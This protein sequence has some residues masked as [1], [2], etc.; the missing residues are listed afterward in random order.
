MYLYLQ[1]ATGSTLVSN[2]SGNSLMSDLTNLD[3]NGSGTPVTFTRISKLSPLSPNKPP[4]DP[5]SLRQHIPH[6][7]G[8]A[9]KG[10]ITTRGLTRHASKLFQKEIIEHIS[11][12]ETVIVY[13]LM[14]KHKIDRDKA[15]RMY[16]EEHDERLYNPKAVYLFPGEVYTP[17][18]EIDDEEE[19]RRKAD[20]FGRV[21]YNHKTKEETSDSYSV[22]TAASVVEQRLI[23]AKKD[24]D[25]EALEHALL[26]SSQ[27]DEFGIN[28][29]DSMSP[30][31][32]VTLEEYVSQ[33]FTREEGAL[34]IFEE[35][36]G[37]TKFTRNS[38]VIPAMPTLQPVHS[39]MTMAGSM[40]DRSGRSGSYYQSGSEIEEEDD[41]EVVDL[42]RR[43]YTREQAFA[44]IEH[45][46]EKALR[47]AATQHP[48][49]P[50]FYD[51]HPR[52]DQLNLSEREEREVQI[53]M[54]QRRCSRRVAVDI[55]V[56][57]RAT[58]ASRNATSTTSSASQNLY[59][60]GYDDRTN[61]SS[62][63]IEVRR[64]IDHG[65]TRE[66]ALQLVRSKQSIQ[67]RSGNSLHS[68]SGHQDPHAA[69][70]R[71]SFGSTNSG[72]NESALTSLTLEEAEIAR[73]TNRGY[74]REQ[75]REMV[76][77]D[78]SLNGSTSYTSSYNINVPSPAVPAS[79][80]RAVPSN[81][82]LETAELVRQQNE[83][84]GVNMFTA[85][86]A[87]DDGVVERLMNDGYTYNQAL[88][89]AFSY[90]YPPRQPAPVPTPQPAYQYQPQQSFYQQPPPQPQYGVS[91]SPYGSPAPYP[92]PYP[93]QAQGSFYQ[94][95]GGSFY[96]QSP[97]PMPMYGNPY[98]PPAPAAAVNVNNNLARNPSSLSNNNSNGSGGG[99]PPVLN[100]N[101]TSLLQQQRNQDA[102]VAQQQPPAA[103]PIEKKASS[104]AM[105]RK[106]S[107]LG[108]IGG[109]TRKSAHTEDDLVARANY[110]ADVDNG[111]RDPDNK[112]KVPKLKYKEADVQKI[113]KMGF[114][115]DQAV[116][117]LIENHQ[118]V[119]QAVHTLT[120]R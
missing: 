14:N 43:G 107:F 2:D 16:L 51:P 80:T 82:D 95:N 7:S 17:V 28:M 105:T 33:G 102:W 32:H 92:T 99:K 112:N 44:V 29:Y 11:E 104:N 18:E 23:G 48:S 5:N 26:L 115:R 54:E 79:R 36:F 117:A 20:L 59:S 76:R 55:V 40:T 25:Q 53:A 19:Q 9:P 34:I 30:E 63:D 62:E 86:T 41:P 49:D 37:K 15:V 119:D 120:D 116:Q 98:P 72:G 100:G 85:G 1:T 12:E 87:E 74:S 94:Q 113:V 4:V 38:E 75:A 61:E 35:K 109:I 78:S 31:D 93:A 73:Y 47:A 101:Q 91:Q 56:A 68:D 13:Q 69:A 66:Q 77:R 22:S 106:G 108:G 114:T 65:Y 52:E 21:E 88:L 67:G 60:A 50:T 27:E 39:H 64:Y 71:P 46:R 58:T 6:A 24:P 118:N 3:N 70:R 110:Q 10:P 111:K 83:D 57:A 96:Q 84:Y 42:M 97:P 89:H 8:G 103:Q 81:L 45:H 90:R